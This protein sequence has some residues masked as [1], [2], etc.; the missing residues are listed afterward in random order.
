VLLVYLGSYALLL[1]FH[2]VPE[3]SVW[4]PSL[5]FA[6]LVLLL[7]GFV[8]QGA[9]FWLDYYRIPVSLTVVAGSMLLYTVTRND[10]YFELNPERKTA[11]AQSALPLEE[12]ARAWKIPPV[13][14]GP[15]QPEKRT[16]VVVTAAGGG[17]Q[18]SAW[19][20]RVLTGLHE[21]YGP[22]FTRSI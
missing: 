13:S 1:L 21:L 3:E 6:L 18:A 4:F 2:G 22:S 9:A 17:I 10:P 7:V 15:G 19:T 12:A 11:Q 8:L 16:L 14:P 20:A 5:F